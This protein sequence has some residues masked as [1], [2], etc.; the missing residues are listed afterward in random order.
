MRHAC[1][2][3]HSRW[4]S[5]LLLKRLQVCIFS[6]NKRRTDLPTMSLFPSVRLGSLTAVLVALNPRTCI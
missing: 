6:P 1:R 5:S 4:L 2:R 3:A